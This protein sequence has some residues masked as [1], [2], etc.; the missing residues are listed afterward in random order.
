M[1]HSAGSEKRKLRGRGALGLFAAVWLNLAL[2]PCAMAYENATDHDCPG[3][4]PAEMTG[5]H[6]GHA[7][8]TVDT[9]CADGLADCMVDDDASLD[10]R[11]GDLKVRDLPAPVALAPADDVA[12]LAP[13]AQAPAPPPFASAHSGAPPP[14]HL[15]NCVFLD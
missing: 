4:P 7:D 13:I 3:C 12:L 11:G 8:A 9:P 5:H 10:S 15:L 14:I 1:S 2:Q 6:G